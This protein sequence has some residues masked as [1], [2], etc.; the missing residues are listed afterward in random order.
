MT[1]ER[2]ALPCR[3]AKK[4]LA[5]VEGGVLI[6]A[7]EPRSAL[8]RLC[9]KLRKRTAGPQMD[10]VLA[11]PRYGPAYVDGGYRLTVIRVLAHCLHIPGGILRFPK[12]KVP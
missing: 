2:A 10:S 4:T 6:S 12:G 5:R 8:L 1:K 3:A 11:E 7:S 9:G